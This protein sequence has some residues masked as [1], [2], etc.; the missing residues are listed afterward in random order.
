MGICKIEVTILT[1]LQTRG[2]KMEFL[3]LY[4][5]KSG[6]RLI[7]TNQSNQ[8]KKLTEKITHRRAYTDSDTWQENSGPHKMNLKFVHYSA[9]SSRWNFYLLCYNTI[10]TQNGSSWE[11]WCNRL[12]QD[13]N[14]MQNLSTTDLVI[15]QGF[16]MIYFYKDARGK[17]LEKQVN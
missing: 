3:L 1:F 7:Q 9:S 12:S 17:P 11:M 16:N 13:S 10:C 8:N 2:T 4:L 5:L 14:L 15:L 6:Q